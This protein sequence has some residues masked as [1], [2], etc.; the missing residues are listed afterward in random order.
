VFIQTT[1]R[2]LSQ[3]QISTIKQTEDSSSEQDNDDNDDKKDDH[4][5]DINY[6]L[7]FNEQQANDDN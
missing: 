3:P 1:E 5:N 6:P 7:T 2:K 4:L